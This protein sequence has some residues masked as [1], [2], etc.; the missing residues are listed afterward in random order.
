MVKRFATALMLGVL[1][2]VNW[3]ALHDIVQREADI[4]AELTVMVL[5]TILFAF[6][7][8]RWLR[9]RFGRST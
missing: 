1:L 3:A 8:G 9:T 7:V 2:A 5:S 4:R 6:L